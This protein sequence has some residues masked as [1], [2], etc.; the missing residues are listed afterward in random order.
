[1]NLTSNAFSAGSPL[2]ARYTADGENHSPPLTFEDIPA[3]AQSLALTLINLDRAAAHWILFNIDP[4][5][6]GLAKAEIAGRYRDGTNAFGS[7]G[8][9]G[10]KGD[11]EHQYAFRLYALDTRLPLPNG[12]DLAQLQDALES[13]ILAEAELRT[14]YGGQ[15]RSNEPSIVSAPAV[16]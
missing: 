5:V 6:N 12:C 15:L 11:K 2:P 13:H 3:G 14:R 10:P 7:L 9:F 8:Y 4:T 16:T 1:M